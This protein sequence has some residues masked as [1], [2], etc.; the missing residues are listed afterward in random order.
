MNAFYELRIYKIFPRKMSEWI[1]FFEKDIVPF[2]IAK[3]MLITGNFHIEEDHETFIW[4]RRFEN[5]E[6][7]KLLY[8]DVYED[9]VWKE[10]FLPRIEKLMDRSAIKVIRMIPN[11]LSI[12][13]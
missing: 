3:G 10:R 5:E 9:K 6:K 2:Q 11:S 12:L 8:K 1:N 7:R 4:I 13:Q